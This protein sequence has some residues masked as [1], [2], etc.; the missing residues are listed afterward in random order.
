M[1]PIALAMNLVLAV[2]LVS[3]LGFG[4]R[5]ERRLKALREGQASFV[6]AVADL[7]RAAR[8]AETGL[9]ELRAATEEAVDLLAGRIE[10][11]RDLAARLERLT[12]AA[13][14]PA[15]ERPAP[16]RL[17]PERLVPERLVPERAEARRPLSE[18]PWAR[19]RRGEAPPEPAEAEAEDLVLGLTER[20]PP[21]ADRPLRLDTRPTPR[22]RASVDD[23]LFEAAPRATAGGR[24]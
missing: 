10:K 19:P 4:V 5:L 9:A 22:S 16:E 6:G 11:A 18:R 3:A 7:D 17:A 15:P 14:R 20:Q 2:L 21:A 23:D 12:S 24:R 1:S 8:R 13:D